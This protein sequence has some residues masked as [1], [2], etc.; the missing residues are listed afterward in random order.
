MLYQLSYFPIIRESTISLSGLGILTGH[1][2]DRRGACGPASQ[3]L[4]RQGRFRFVNM[5][6][7]M[8]RSACLVNTLNAQ[9]KKGYSDLSV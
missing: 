2:T 7:N 8:T 4:G 3:W 5:D 6:G 1:A 9:E